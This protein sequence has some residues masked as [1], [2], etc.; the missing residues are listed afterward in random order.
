MIKHLSPTTHIQRVRAQIAFENAVTAISMRPEFKNATINDLP[1]LLK[2][3][4]VNGL[5]VNIVDTDNGI[6]VK[7]KKPG[8]SPVEWE[9]LHQPTGG[10]YPLI[11]SNWNKRVTPGE[12]VVYILG[13]TKL[14]K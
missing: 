12:A 7:T 5:V 2:E 14:T 9:F 10:K 6:D 11:G 13:L 4:N 1:K 3:Q 8:F